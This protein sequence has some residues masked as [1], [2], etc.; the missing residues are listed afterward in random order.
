MRGIDEVVNA[1]N[2]IQFRAE[3]ISEEV[4]KHCWS[5][6]GVAN[7]HIERL[8]SGELKFSPAV[9]AEIQK[10]FERANEVVKN[11]SRNVA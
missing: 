7:R 3:D 8:I 5:E 1:R 2:E 6:L 11:A 10:S 9:A 4:A